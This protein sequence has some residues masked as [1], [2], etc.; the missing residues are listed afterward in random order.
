MKRIWLAFVLVAAIGALIP[1]PDVV[2]QVNFPWL[3]AT[4]H[5]PA[6]VG[7]APTP[8]GATGGS[9]TTSA[10][11]A[12]CAGG[13]FIVIEVCGIAGTVNTATISDSQSNTY[14]AL[15]SSSASAGNRQGALFYA[16]HA[17]TAAS[18]TFS[19][20]AGNTGYITIIPIVFSDMNSTPFDQQNTGI[21]NSTGAGFAVGNVTTLQS[22]LI[23]AGIC[24]Y[25]AGSG[26]YSTTS[27]SMTVGNSFLNATDM[28]GAIFWIN[29]T[30]AGS[31]NPNLKGNGEGANASAGS[32]ATFRSIK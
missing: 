28:G 9:V 26:T 11:G 25:N 2:A 17:K 22:E 24:E 32:I 8:V 29:Q 30:V 13:N 27:P 21:G 3:P 7:T 23:I 1:A 19:G 18:M 15:N 20:T 14:S 12:C 16:A 4:S 6:F 10:S 5:T 31:A